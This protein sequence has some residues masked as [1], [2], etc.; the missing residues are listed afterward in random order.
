MTLYFAPLNFILFLL[1]Q[2]S[3]FSGSLHSNFLS[4]AVLTM[5]QDILPSA[6]LINPLLL[7]VLQ[8]L[9]KTL[10][11]SKGKFLWYY[12]SALFSCVLLIKKVLLHFKWM[13]RTEFSFSNKSVILPNNW[14]WFNI[15]T[16]F[17]NPIL[18]SIL[19]PSSSFTYYFFKNLFKK[20]EYH[21]F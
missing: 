20:L 2:S 16:I 1:C 19:F 12:H 4:S 21:W 7:P 15:S 18:H 5:P 17:C 3:R 10:D 9:V 8:L 6:N 14:L 11:L 13:K